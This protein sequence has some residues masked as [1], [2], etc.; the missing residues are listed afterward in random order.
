[1]TSPTREEVSSESYMT[2]SGETLPGAR[3]PKPLLTMK[4]TTKIGT[5]NVH[6][7]YETSKAA[8]VEN[9]KK[10]ALCSTRN[11]MA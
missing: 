11:V 2:P 9:E 7:M 10:T 6:T 5:W 4:A 8:Q 1:M 3:W